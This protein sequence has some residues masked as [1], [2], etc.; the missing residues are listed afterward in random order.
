MVETVFVSDNNAV[1][2]CPECSKT[3]SVDISRYK[4][5][6]MSSVIKCTCFCGH[7]YHIKLA[8]RKAARRKASIIGMYTHIVSNVGDN[9]CE[10]IGKGVVTI[11]DISHSGL[12]LK[13]NAKPR[14]EG[15][16]RIMIEFDL[17]D[18]N[19]TRI[20][21]ELIIR[22]IKDKKVGAEFSSVDPNNANDKAIGDYLKNK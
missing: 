3:R 13:F 1:F 7:S 15:G 21:K 11:V 2:V 16:D 4:N 20:K 14:F 8:K 10:E 19:K 22:N 6:N 12:L 17:D 9:F 5:L 18:S